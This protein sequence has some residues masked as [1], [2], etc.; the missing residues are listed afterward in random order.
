MFRN[1]IK[2]AFR[3]LWKNKTYSFLNIM[4][5]SIGITCA[6]LIFLWVEDELTY[7]HHNEKIDQLYQV[8]ENQP[9]EG[10][11]YTFTATPGPLAAAAKEEIPGIKNSCRT[12]W[13]ERVLFNKG[14]K[15][16]F[17]TGFY[18]DSS[19]FSM[20]SIHFVQGSREKVFQQL[21]SLVISETMAKKFFGNDANV[22]GK[23]LKVDN[24]NEF[25]ITGVVKDLPQ[26]STLK[27][28][29][30]A[31]FKIYLDK[32]DWLLQWGNNGI[33]TYIELE[34]SA[35]LYTINKKMHGYIK[36]KDTSAVA[37][38]FLLGMN[39]WRLH[40]SFKDG[41]PDTGRIKHVRTFTTI[42]WIILLIACINFM[43][44]A[45]ARSEKRAR[46][47]GVRK[48]L[49][50]GKK[51]LILQFIGEAMLMS[52]IAVIIAIGIIYLVLPSFNEL[53]EKK[54]YLA[55]NNPV[56]NSALI[57][58][59][60]ICGLVAGSYPSIYLSSFSPTSVLKGLKTRGSSAAW[61]RKG[62]VV[63]QFTISIVLIISTI[64][65]YQQIQFAK[66]RDLGFNKDNL[67]QISLEGSMKKN[68]TALKQDLL[69][70]GQVENTAMAM[71][72]IL[73]MGSNTSDF[74]W[75]G[76]DPSSKILV[77]QDF[78]SPEYISTTGMKI[79]QG[80]DFNQDAKSD[81]LNIIINQA[82]AKMV[83]KENA[84][85]KIITRD[86]VKY[87]IIGVTDDFVYGDMYAKGDPLIFMVYPDYYNYMYVKLK[88]NSQTQNAL[89]RIES[90]LK[91]H[92]PG[93][94][95]DYKFVDENFNKIF[96]TETLISKLSRI[97]A[98][99]A[100]FISCLGLFGLAAYTA[101]RRTKEIG[102]RKVLGAS[103]QGIATLLSSDFLKLVFVSFIIAFP[104]A[105][106]FMNE[107]LKDYAYRIDIDWTVFVIAGM[108][109][110]LIALLTISFQAIR[111]GLS[112]PIK[113]LRTE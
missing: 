65:I 48:V 107:F 64:I 67:I 38:P 27:F 82:L 58:I 11:I 28:E 113:S 91:T 102:I 103:V 81:S 61:I 55:L 105:W 13:Q 7:N 68:Y 26:N 109:S 15:S 86:S 42:A 47:V 25:F 23:T 63:I 78:I 108:I 46:E 62:L 50:A 33:L 39:D 106:W 2:T 88:Q 75:A 83:D 10:K 35:D 6:A 77:T 79:K 93:Y 37:Q 70:T 32:N 74:S 101:E 40:N 73:W 59:A 112:N 95:F 56:H 54:L 17:E 76:K 53:V 89:S 97:F 60:L 22:I 94:P 12:T 69:A 4:G 34:T 30:V 44:L 71:L 84:V 66:N 52:V 43:N 87:T 90:I 49:G 80:R 9:Y 16:I 100:I 104:L 19:L 85:G 72:N 21:H 41:K 92:N 8:Y 14:D 18:A 111:A 24:Q 45:T 57:A 3:N 1:Y 98:I 31:P 29:W 96:Q 110:V 20:F 36:S 51:M 99:L 5:L